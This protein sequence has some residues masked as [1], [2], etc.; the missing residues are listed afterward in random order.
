MFLLG[1]ASNRPKGKG[2]SPPSLEEEEEN[3]GI[4]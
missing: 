2:R 1:H 4:L 3:K